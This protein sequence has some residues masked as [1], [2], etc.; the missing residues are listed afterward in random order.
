[1]FM[2]KHLT[3]EFEIQ[4]FPQIQ[5]NAHRK[6]DLYHLTLNKVGKNP[7]VR[8]NTSTAIRSNTW[9]NQSIQ[10]T[11]IRIFLWRI[12]KQNGFSKKKPNRDELDLELRS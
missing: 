10:S 3:Y 9:I 11:N 5:S 6:L 1:M 8:F 4:I 2:D 12:L 7:D